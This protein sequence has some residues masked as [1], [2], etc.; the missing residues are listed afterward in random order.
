VP[1]TQAQRAPCLLA[2][3]IHRTHRHE[4][5]GIRSRPHEQGRLTGDEVSAVRCVAPGTFA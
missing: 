4:V 2:H 1:D 3:E 5:I